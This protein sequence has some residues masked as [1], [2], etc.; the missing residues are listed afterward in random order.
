MANK[1]Q[2][3]QYLER[4]KPVVLRAKNGAKIIVSDCSNKNFW[5]DLGVRNPIA[6]S[7]EWN[8]HQPPHLWKLMF[9]ELG[10]SHISTKWTTRREFL[11][12]GKILLANKF[13]SYLMGSHFVSLYEKM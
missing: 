7:I 12:P 8:L 13:C 2:W 6:P 3:E 1:D 9:E 5:N 11:V 4:L 10:C